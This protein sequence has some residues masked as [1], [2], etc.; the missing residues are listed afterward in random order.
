MVG[1]GEMVGARART[2]LADKGLG[3][4]WVW[5][6]IVWLG[7]TR[8]SED[9][10][11]ARWVLWLALAF[12][13]AAALF[14]GVS[15]CRRSGMSGQ[16]LSPRAAGVVTLAAAAAQLGVALMP[17]AGTVGA[18]V[19]CVLGVVCGALASV[20][21]LAHAV[22]LASRDA[23]SLEL[24]VPVCSLLS[25]LTVVVTPLPDVPYWLVA[26]GLLVLAGVPFLVPTS[27]SRPD[28]AF[29]HPAPSAEET[30]RAR[31]DVLR[32]G[33]VTCVTYTLIK[34]AGGSPFDSSWAA[35]GIWNAIPHLFGVLAAVCIAVLSLSHLPRLSMAAIMKIVMPAL[36]IAVLLSLRPEPVCATV[37]GVLMALAEAPLIVFVTL[38][39]FKLA[40]C[41]LVPAAAGF[42]ALMGAVQAGVFLGSC[43][44]TPGDGRGLPFDVTLA[45]LCGV[46]VLAC[47]LVPSEAR[48]DGLIASGGAQSAS[49]MT[50][51]AVFTLDAACAELACRCDLSDRERDVLR[52]LARGYG[53]AYIRD[54]LVISKNTVATHA[55]HIYQKTGVHSQQELIALVQGLLSD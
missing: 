23:D 18:V 46:F 36:V 1:E 11:H 22:R 7:L 49:P 3:I 45:V 8:V 55:R 40:R 10:P 34:F 51:D 30:H 52:L 15:A 53:R 19:R 33:L 24:L 37:A 54:V 20:L 32:V 50:V 27:V 14:A 26:A 48:D 28:T 4:L 29:P 9:V 6:G 12:G 41:G 44:L 25:V 35:S 13:I 38:F 42:G 5:M 16:F 17:A 47:S 2:G 31:I 43:L 39:T 21:M